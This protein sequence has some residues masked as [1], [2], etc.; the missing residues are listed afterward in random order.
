MI[1]LY[2]FISGNI[3]QSE[4]NQAMNQL[5][6]FKCRILVSTDLT[7]RG[8]DAS[9]VDL[10]VCMDLAADPET[11]LHR[12]GRAGRYGCQGTAVSFICEKDEASRFEEIIDAYNLRIHQFTGF[13][14]CPFY[15]K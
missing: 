9:D 10:I 11:Y 4:R 14:I 13:N 15:L 8:I 6:Q 12:I 1:L 2:R 5:K 3:D 7:A